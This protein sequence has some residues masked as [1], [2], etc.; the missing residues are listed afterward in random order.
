MSPLEFAQKIDW[1]GGL[2]S[3][4]MSYGLSVDDL[5]DDVD[6]LAKNQLSELIENYIQSVEELK[7]FFLL[8]FG[9]DMD[10]VEV[11]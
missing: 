7:E 11:V 1:E 8:E 5:D 3:A 2:E 10:S 9:I 4:F 6:E